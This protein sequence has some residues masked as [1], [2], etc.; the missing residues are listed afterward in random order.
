MEAAVE[1]LTDY[2]LERGKPMPDLIHG[3]IQANITGEM[4]LRYRQEYTLASEVALAT[5]PTGSTPDVVIYEHF[6]PDYDHRPPRTSTPPLCCV[7][8]QSPSQ[9]MEE[10]IAKV[11]IYFGFGVRSCWLIQPAVR[12]V[13]VFDAPDNY[14]F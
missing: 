13:F 5:E 8:I 2:E 11:K 9:S 4:R 1:Q 12:G 10:M 3:F 14:G 7:E 6:T